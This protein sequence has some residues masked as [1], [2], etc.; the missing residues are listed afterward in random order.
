MEFAACD[1][2]IIFERARK[3]GV[4][5][6]T[7]TW[8]CVGARVRQDVARIPSQGVTIAIFLPCPTRAATVTLLSRTIFAL[9]IDDEGEKKKQRGLRFKVGASCPFPQSPRGET[10]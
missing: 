3:T 4:K 9:T 2:P 1:S 7:E 8:L 6:E 5:L 10:S